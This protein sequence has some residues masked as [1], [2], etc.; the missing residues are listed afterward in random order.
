MTKVIGELETDTELMHQKSL[1]EDMT[2][3]RY[4]SSKDLK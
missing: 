1:W 4:Y 2:D 3:D